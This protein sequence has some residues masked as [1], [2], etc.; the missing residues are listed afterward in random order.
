M[1]MFNDGGY[2]LENSWVPT[3]KVEPISQKDLSTIAS[4]EIKHNNDVLMSDG[5]RVNFINVIVAFKDGTKK[6]Y[7][8]SKDAAQTQFADGTKIDPSSIKMVEIM[9]QNGVTKERME[10]KA[11]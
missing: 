8:L 4:A 2:S 6:S 9:D 3:G 10:C 7:Q 11:L 1:S 5:T